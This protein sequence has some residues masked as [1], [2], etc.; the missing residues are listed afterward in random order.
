MGVKSINNYTFDAWRV[1]Q[2]LYLHFMGNYDF[3]KYHGTGSWDSVQQMEKNFAKHERHGKFSVQRNIF[4][5][6]GNR[7]NSKE[8]LKLFFLSQFTYNLT[9]PSLFDSEVYDDYKTRMNNFHFHLREDMKQVLEYMK[10]YDKTFDEMF[11]ANGV[12][13]P[14]LLKLGLSR[15]ISLETF[16]TLDIVLN[17]ISMMNKRLVDPAWKD[18]R[19]LVLKYKP[20]LS[21]NVEKEQKIIR[22]II[23]EQKV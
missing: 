3:H 22:D 4:K 6:L 11:V 19:N 18:F 10:E 8:D 17:F 5:K 12:N 13:H 7:F 16:V 20:F 1:Y 9:Y 15:T 2:G 21:L 14:S 23:C